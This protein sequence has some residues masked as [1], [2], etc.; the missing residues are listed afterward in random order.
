M[1]AFEGVTSS[2]W[3]GKKKS[4]QVYVKV[5]FG[6]MEALTV[7]SA[8]A[9]NIKWEMSFEVFAVDTNSVGPSFVSIKN[10]SGKVQK[11]LLLRYL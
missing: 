6:S 1:L 11:Q 7:T 10:S 8:L 9:C 4:T 3:L 5:S 2:A